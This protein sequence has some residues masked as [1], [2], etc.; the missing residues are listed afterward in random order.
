MKLA[1]VAGGTDEV[2]WESVAAG[3]APDY[4]GYESVIGASSA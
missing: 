3:M 2:L 1:R 4:G